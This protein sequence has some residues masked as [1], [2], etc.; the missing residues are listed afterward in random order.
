M[1]IERDHQIIINIYWYWFNIHYTIYTY[2]VLNRDLYRFLMITYMEK[3]KTP[4]TTV[5]SM[6][7]AECEIQINV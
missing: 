3:V 7:S 5:K 4:T 6:A 2:I 1:T